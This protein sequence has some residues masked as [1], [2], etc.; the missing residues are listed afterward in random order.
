M[1]ESD[2]IIRVIGLNAGYKNKVIIKDINFSVHRGEIFVII[3]RSGCGK[4]T[5]LK[6][7][8]GLYSPI[9]GDILIN[10]ISISHS[11]GEEKKK[12]MRSFGVLYQSGALFNSYTIGENVALPL[13]EFTDFSSAKIAEIVK[14]KLRLVGL[15]GAENLMPHQCSGGMKK[16]AGLARAMALDPEILF[17]DEPSA[18]LDPVTAA[19]LD[20]LI[21]DLRERLRTT[22]V[23]VSHE[24]DSIYAI[25]DRVM[26]L[27]PD[28]KTTIAIGSPREL[29]DNS[30]NQAVREFFTRDGLIS[31]I[32]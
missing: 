22:M 30:E 1:N 17:F 32:R 3:G 25:A 15:E 5:L 13:E 10:S 11:S 12:I 19:K 14:E 2:Q 24:L 29:R 31:K 4:T 16:R 7:M 28:K 26:M 18:G 20:R 21:I 6:H 27:D 9:S 8:I 23:I